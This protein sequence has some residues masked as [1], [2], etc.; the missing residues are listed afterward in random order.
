MDP[1]EQCE[2]VVVKVRGALVPKLGRG[3]QR[4]L[5]ALWLRSCL[6]PRGAAWQLRQQLKDFIKKLHFL[7]PR[8]ASVLCFAAERLCG[9][10]SGS[11]CLIRCKRPAHLSRGGNLL[12][13]AEKAAPVGLGPSGALPCSSCS[14]AL[15]AQRGKQ[16]FHVV[17][18]F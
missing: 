12:T 13:L 6:C 5:P 11:T 17:F 4:E 15:A 3:Q 8:S 1:T 2:E 7:K 9:T 10:L 18:L 14:G 16:N